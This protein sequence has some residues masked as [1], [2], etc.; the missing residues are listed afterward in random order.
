MNAA[1]AKLARLIMLTSEL[2]ALHRDPDFWVLIVLHGQ[3]VWRGGSG[4]PNSARR[5][6]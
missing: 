6:R 5:A 2:G 4:L 1:E 3:R